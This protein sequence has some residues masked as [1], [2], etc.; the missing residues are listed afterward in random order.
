MLFFGFRECERSSE[1]E[2]EE[3]MRKKVRK[4]STVFGTAHGCQVQKI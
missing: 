4:K 3:M 1:E 2:E